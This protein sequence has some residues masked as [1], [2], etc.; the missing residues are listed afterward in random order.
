MA[1]AVLLAAISAGCGGDDSTVGSTTTT[2][3]TATTV[4]PTP[5][6]LELEVIET[7]DR[8]PSSFT[9][10]LEYDGESLFESA[11]LY[12]RSTLRRLDAETLAL[13]DEVA[14]AP[15]QFAEGLTVVDDRVIQLTWKA[16]VAHIYDTDT[17]EIVGDF[18]YDGE[19]WGLC[20]DG[21]SLF[22]SNG[23]DTLVRRDAE[24]FEVQASLPVG[25]AN[26]NELEC[27]DG[28]VYANVWQTN[29]ILEIDPSTG[30]VLAEIDATEI[31]PATSQ[32]SNGDVLNGIAHIAGTDTYLL[33]GK[34]WPT[35]TVV[36]LVP[37][38]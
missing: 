5:V 8:D 35:A 21:S 22:M 9:Q 13:I 3:G 18:S 38:G 14:L 34:R 30:G 7:L 16:G 31:V 36:R 1:T 17:L 24:T 33:T 12:G 6:G 28:R 4:A 26:L 29:K 15:E 10:G 23:S 11:G 25:V 2:V 37:T 20:Y 19:G 32:A 27:N